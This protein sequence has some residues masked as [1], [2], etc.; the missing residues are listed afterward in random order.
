M[1]CHYLSKNTCSFQT[2][3][4][5]IPKDMETGW[6]RN[7]ASSLLSNMPYIHWYQIKEICIR[8]TKLFDTTSYKYFKKKNLIKIIVTVGVT[9]HQEKI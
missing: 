9:I 8:L 5:Q 4:E 2:W 7:P 6:E 3:V 1:E